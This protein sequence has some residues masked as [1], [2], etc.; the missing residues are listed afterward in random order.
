M[1]GEK[2]REGEGGREGKGGERE[3]CAYSCMHVV[4]CIILL[5]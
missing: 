5:Y 1:C 4:Y 3:R 2:Q